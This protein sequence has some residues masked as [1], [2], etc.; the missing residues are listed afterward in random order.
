MAQHAKLLCAM[1]ISITPSCVAGNFGGFCKIA[2]AVV[3]VS[4]TVHQVLTV[5]ALLT[6]ANLALGFV[7][8]TLG[9]TV[10]SKVIAMRRTGSGR[11]VT[12]TLDQP[13]ETGIRCSFTALKVYAVSTC[14]NSGTRETKAIISKSLM[15]LVKAGKPWDLQMSHT[16]PW[17]LC[18]LLKLGLYITTE[19]I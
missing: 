4:A 17:V 5:M 14:S 6:L 18:N 7:Y 10:P 16:I 11:S 1:D 12:V 13:P 2:F 15:R 19:E 8:I 3:D 9:S